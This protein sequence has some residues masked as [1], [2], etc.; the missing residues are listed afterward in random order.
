[1][2]Q[3]TW[4]KYVASI[5]LIWAVIDVSIP[6]V[7][8]SEGQLEHGPTAVL[9]TSSSNSTGTH[10]SRFA[11]EDDCFCCCSHIVASPH[12]E[13]GDVLNLS[14]ANLAL[15]LGLPLESVETIPHPPRS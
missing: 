4:Q 9:L 15:S 8:H 14:P 10:S 7:C 2:K 6:A 13:L 11:Y 5:L 1:M 12:F 3:H